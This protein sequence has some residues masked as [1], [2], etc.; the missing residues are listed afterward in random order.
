MGVRDILKF[1]TAAR[2][3]WIRD[4]TFE[5]VRSIELRDGVLGGCLEPFD[6]VGWWMNGEFHAVFKD[7]VGLGKFDGLTSIQ[8]VYDRCM[9][10]SFPQPLRVGDRGNDQNARFNKPNQPK[11][12]FRKKQ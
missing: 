12:A 4:E 1:Y 6:N 8:I 3:N 5:L 9:Y 7:I 11:P 10:F 2:K